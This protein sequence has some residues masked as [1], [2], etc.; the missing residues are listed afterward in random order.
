MDLEIIILSELSDRQGQILY[1]ISYMQNLKKKYKWTK[2]TY[3]QNSN[4]FTDT[5]N[6]LM[7]TKGER[8]GMRDKLEGWD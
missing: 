4:R 8:E 3:I 7:A 6:N 5:E 1:S 2:W